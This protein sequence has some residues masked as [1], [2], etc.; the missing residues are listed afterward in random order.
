MV[1]LH[2]GA[3]GTSFNSTYVTATP[4]GMIAVSLLAHERGRRTSY[5]LFSFRQFCPVLIEQL[6]ASCDVCGNTSDMYF[7]PLV[8]PRVASLFPTRGGSLIGG[9][10]GNR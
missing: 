1:Y 3:I 2:K 4:L 5:A 10:F 6:V 7:L 9:V 8:L